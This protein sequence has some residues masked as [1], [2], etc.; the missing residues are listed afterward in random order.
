MEHSV[1]TRRE[2]LGVTLLT[3]SALAAPAL[4]AGDVYAQGDQPSSGEKKQTKWSLSGDY[5]EN[6]NCNV[7]CP[8]L[9]SPAPPL[10]SRPT[11]G[12]CHVAFLFHIDKGAYGD[13]KLDGLNAV[14]AISSQGPM[15]SG[16]WT[17]AAYLDER[18]DEKQ[19]EALG[20]IFGGTAGG[21]M[22]AFAPLVGKSLGVKK[23]SITYKIDGKVRSGEIPG[24]LSMSVRPLQSIVGGEEIWVSPGAATNPS[25]IALA[26]GRDGSTYADYGL[27]W[28]NSGRNG[29]YAPINWSG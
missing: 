23:A 11:E 27:R 22:A 16:H 19:T 25:K 29:H 13:L 15:A 2:L 7:T 1:P 26:V 17:S 3:A 18:A 21:P 24:V 8:C 4:V 6:C 20:A 10:T 5:F 28:D 14:V 12:D 9:F